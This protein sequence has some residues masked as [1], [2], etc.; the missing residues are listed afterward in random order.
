[1]E[2]YLKFLT[3]TINHSFK[4]STFPNKLKHSEVIPGYK[5]LEPF[6]EE[7]YRPVSLLP[8]ISKGFERVIYELINNF[9]ENRIMVLCHGFQE[10]TWRTAYFNSHVRKME[11]SLR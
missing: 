5:K 10:I 8:H 3:N 9:M 4:E 1:M 7:N 6:Q 2:V 11:K